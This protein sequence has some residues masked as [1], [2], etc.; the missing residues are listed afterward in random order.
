MEAA[1]E[2]ED[3]AKEEENKE[4]EEYCLYMDLIGKDLSSI[5]CM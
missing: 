2:E 3:K 5:K 1:N 4:E